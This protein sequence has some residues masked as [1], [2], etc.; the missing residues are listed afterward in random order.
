[1]I[2]DRA[3]DGNT[4]SQN[5]FVGGRAGASGGNGGGTMNVGIG[6][7]ALYGSGTADADYNNA[8]GAYCME[9]NTGGHNNNAMGYEALE[10][11]TT[12]LANTALGH[13]AMSNN[14]TGAYNTAMGYN[15]GGK[16]PLE[17]RMFLQDVVLIKKEPLVMIVL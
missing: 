17:H 16:L 6:F 1:M 13:Q 12:G 10:E 7:W 5:T 11:N 15:A 14:T 3:G 8:I 9:N 4:G 2:G